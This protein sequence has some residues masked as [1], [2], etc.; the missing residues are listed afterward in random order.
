MSAPAG[1]Q[2]CDEASVQQK[3]Q[4][5][6][7]LSLDLRG[8]LPDIGELESVVTNGD[9]DPAIIRGMVRSD[10]AISRLRN[11]HRD[12]LWVNVANQRLANNSW[13]LR[14]GGRGGVARDV[15]WIP[16]NQRTN[17]YR[18]GQGPCADR[19]Q[20]ELG[21]DATT[22]RPN[23]QRNE[24]LGINQEGYEMVEPYW[25]PGT[26]V[27]VCAFE[28][29]DNLQYDNGRGQMIPCSRGIASASC[30]CGPNLQWCHN[31][32]VSVATIDQS[33]NEQLLRYADE[34]IR[35]DR[36]YSDLLVGKDMQVNGPISHYFRYQTGGG[37]NLVLA[38]PD[39]GYTMPSIPYDQLEGWQT[40]QRGTR[41]AGVLTMPAFFLKFQSDRGRAN[42]FYNAFLCTSFEAPEGGL[43]AAD[44]D[45]H[46]EP[47]LTKRCGCQHCHVAVE[48]AAAHWGRWAEAGML[49]MN[50]QQF[51][52]QNPQCLTAQGA[53]NNVCRLFYQT[54][55][56]HPDEEAFLGYLKSYVFADQ[57]RQANIEQGPEKLAR[58]AIDSGQFATCTA[59]KMWALFMTR[60]AT[61]E[62]RPVI[63]QLAEDFKQG[64]DLRS[65]IETIVSRPEYIEAGRFTGVQE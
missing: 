39:Q 62:E 51:P 57:E 37:G 9:V 28:A 5:V 16:A 3:L 22:G 30:G 7:R 38:S 44:D 36:P 2:V 10:D 60:E 42:R 33:F 43:P 40:V 55:A 25:A 26:Q 45:C 12:L 47:D 14:T 8:R 19:P 27:K 18:G 63:T 23:T 49:P 11:Y 65:L 52:I 29:Q 17:M 21:Y 54:T 41:H 13:I 6:R 1:A 46:N 20:S 31:N 48:P 56:G 53:R 24:Q 64:Y 61:A 35:G 34:I 50:E 58:T 4:Y 32:N 15:M 59:N